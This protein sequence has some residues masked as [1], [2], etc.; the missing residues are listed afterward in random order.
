MKYIMNK[1]LQLLI[2]CLLLQNTFALN[3][4]ISFTGSGAS[5]N[6][7]SI[8]VQNITKGTS[9]IVQEGNTLN[10]TDVNS[11][12][13]NLNAINDVIR[14]I[15]GEAGN[16]ILQFNAET[17]GEY[18]ISIYNTEGR[19]VTEISENLPVGQNSFEL[20][21]PQGIFIINI[22]GQGKSY[23]VKCSNQV[24]T[25]NYV[26]IRYSGSSKVLQNNVQKIKTS[27]STTTMNYSDGDLLIFKGFSG[28]YSTLVSKYPNK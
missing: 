28:E 1:P 2:F 21:F 15:R 23:S 16:N 8:L 4:T 25:K 5:T 12:I 20:S 14:I 13:E 11:G 9:I 22:F 3:Y 18:T 26:E 19:R 6:I 17:S 27:N 10:L 24:S 7:D